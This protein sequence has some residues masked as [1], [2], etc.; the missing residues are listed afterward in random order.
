[1]KWISR[2][3]LKRDSREL[4]KLAELALGSLYGE[5]QLVWRFMEE[6]A[7]ER[8]RWQGKDGDAQP[9]FLYRKEVEQGNTVFYLL[10]Q[11]PPKVESLLWACET[12]PYAPQLQVGERIAFRLR[13]NPTVGRQTLLGTAALAKYNEGR[14]ARGLPT[15]PSRHK[16]QF[17]DVLFCAKRRAEQQGLGGGELDR[18]VYQAGCDWL[19]RQGEKYGLAV[20]EV[21]MGGYQSNKAENN[22]DAPIVFSSVDYQGVARI[23]NLALLDKALHEG[24]GRAKGFGCGLLLIRRVAD[25]EE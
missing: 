2:I 6:H 21:S 11:H 12:K 9:L 23:K 13:A 1:M 20:E 8:G 18:Q 3:R 4:Q 10:S 25:H 17:D 5:H 24:V 19:H 22:Q 14:V 7:S 16:R 15:K